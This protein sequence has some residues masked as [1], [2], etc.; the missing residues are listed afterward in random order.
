MFVSF[1][2]LYGALAALS[3]SLSLALSLSFFRQGYGVGVDPLHRA[4]QRPRLL[5]GE[6]V[7]RSPSA[8]TADFAGCSP[9]QLESE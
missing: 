9:Q 2:S 5:W 8:A 7:T 1:L 4:R 6:K 3:L